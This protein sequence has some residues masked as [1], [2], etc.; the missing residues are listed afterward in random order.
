MAFQADYRV[1]WRSRATP[2]L[3]GQDRRPGAPAAALE[4]S[5]AC[6]RSRDE[7][8]PRGG[9]GHRSDHRP[10]ISLAIGSHLLAIVSRS[11]PFHRN[12]FL[13]DRSQLTTISILIWTIPGGTG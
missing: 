4:P 13:A 7:G 11:K 10:K 3:A 1:R 12:S 6:A 5:R 2:A 9:A 8:G